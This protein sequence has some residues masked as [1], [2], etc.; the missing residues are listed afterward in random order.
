[1]PNANEPSLAINLEGLG[2]TN[3]E[4]KPSIMNMLPSFYGR[5]NESPLEHITEFIEVCSTLG[6]LGVPQESIK[7]KIFPFTLKDKARAWF[8][9]LTGGSITSWDEL[10]ARFHQKFY[11][12]SRTTDLRTALRTFSQYNHEPFHETWERFNDLIRQCPHHGY[13]RR[14]LMQNLYTGLTE[15][16]RI[17]VNAIAGGS[18]LSL[19][20][21]DAWERLERL[22][23]DSY[24]NTSLERARGAPR[25]GMSEV[26][27]SSDLPARVDALTQ[28]LDQF[29]S[30]SMS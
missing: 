9:A 21:N 6:Y 26:H 14:E 3:F 11:P 29:I 10:S 27:M 20:S 7:L 12:M 5:T 13:N 15:S 2:N 16:Q 30:I 8:R 4:L 25:R 22:A 1:M 28:K 23:E 17:T 19:S 24:Q 18:F